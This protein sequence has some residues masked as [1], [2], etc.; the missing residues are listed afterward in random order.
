MEECSSTP[1]LLHT[2]LILDAIL[3]HCTSVAIDY[4]QY[5]LEGSAATSTMTAP[6]SDV[7]GH[8]KKKQNKT[9]VGIT[10]RHNLVLLMFIVLLHNS[11]NQ[12][13][14]EAEVSDL[15]RT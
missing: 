8:H 10:F 9:T 14:C 13:P 5:F 2:Y 1:F 7:S 11:K 15:P 4:M 12:G 6:T 3:S